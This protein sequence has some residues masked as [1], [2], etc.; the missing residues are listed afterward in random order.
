MDRA[1]LIAGAVCSA[2]LQRIPRVYEF[3]ESRAIP[4]QAVTEELQQDPN[5]ISPLF[6]MQDKEAARVPVNPSFAEAPP[7]AVLKLPV[8]SLTHRVDPVYPADAKQARIQ[9]TVRFH[10]ALAKDGTVA[11]L[12]LFSGHPLLVQSATDAVKQWIYKPTLLNGV[13]VVSCRF[14][15]RRILSQAPYL[16]RSRNFRK[17]SKS[18]EICD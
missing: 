17:R 7:T 15:S 18:P 12:Q 5:N 10:A 2:Q 8:A 6:S 9:A 3:P 11:N 13:P 1:F 4:E 16:S 14:L